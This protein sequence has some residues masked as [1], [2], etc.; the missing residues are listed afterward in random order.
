M[1]SGAWPMSSCWTDRGRSSPA[2]RG[3]LGIAGDDWMALGSA[4]FLRAWAGHPDFRLVK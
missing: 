4:E 2:F 1:S 3:V